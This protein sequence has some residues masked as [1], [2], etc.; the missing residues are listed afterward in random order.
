[1]A[2]TVARGWGVWVFT[3]PTLAAMDRSRNPALGVALVACGALLFTLNAGVSRVALRHGVSAE[4]LTTLRLTG[5]LAFLVLAA[6]LFRRSALRPPRGRTLLLVVAHG[7]IGVALLQLTYFVAI[8]RLPVGMALLIEYQA[9]VIVALWARFVYR[10][11]V[12]RRLWAGLGLAVVGLALATE[13]WRGA[14]FDTLG[15]LAGVG[16]ALSYSCYFLIGEA[17]VGRLDPLRVALWSFL[18]AT[19]AMNLLFPLGGL[20]VSLSSSAPLLGRL[21]EWALPLA[22]VLLW[23][24]ALGTLAP[25][26]MQLWALQFVPATT[27]TAIALL[28]PIG[29]SALGW[30]WFGETL[31]FVAVLGCVAVVAGIV[32]A[33]SARRPHAEVEPPAIT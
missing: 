22:L 31:S 17:G 14:S 20:D 27:V 21:D 28:E 5:T 10:E 24:V 32:L 25:F 9:P 11:R 18:V 6:L 30:W 2:A 33:Q 15:L 13:V 7:L 4:V 1:M 29:V 19:V 26:F 8:D 12:H 23:I 3:G 16:A